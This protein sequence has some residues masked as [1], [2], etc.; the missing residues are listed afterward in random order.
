MLGL[1][2]YFPANKMYECLELLPRLFIFNFLKAL[3][4]DGLLF[5][6]LYL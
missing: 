2:I 3:S 1:L 4:T 5:V 6:V